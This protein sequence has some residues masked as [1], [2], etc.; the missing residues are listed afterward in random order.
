MFVIICLIFIRLY[1]IYLQSNWKQ[2]EKF[3]NDSKFASIIKDLPSFVQSARSN[4]T[5]KKYECYFKKF[6]KWC[7]SNSLP[8]LPAS[9]STIALYIGGLI[10]QGCSVAVLESHF[11]S[12]KWFH[13]FH[14]KYN[15][16]SDV[17]LNLILEGCRRLLSKPVNKKQPITPD[18]LKKVVFMYGDPFDL[19]KLRIVL[20]FLMGF[21]GF[22]RYSELAN[23]KMNK[24]E[25]FDNYV[26]INIE[27]SKTDKYR[28]GNSIVIASTGTD[29]CPVKWLKIYI[30]LAGLRLNSDNYVFRALSFIKSLGTY[31][32]CNE[33]IPLSYT[34][35]REILLEALVGIGLDKS[36]YGLHSV[37]PTGSMYPPYL[38]PS[39]STG[40]GTT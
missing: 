2:F 14:F 32:L 11:Y 7:I 29:M 39:P 22:L 20:I 15:P 3:A 36:K 26:K 12:I 13:D 21:S 17:F 5:I 18:I 31:K 19:K 40:I 38:H 27:K 30:N 28:R 34:R 6:E 33:N 8:F 9:V 16:C 4:S 35:A 24:I 37:V 23:I 25:F 1:F 10:Q